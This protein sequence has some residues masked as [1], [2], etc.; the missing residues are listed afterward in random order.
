MRWSERTDIRAC[1]TAAVGGDLIMLYPR[2][3]CRCSGHPAI[4]ATTTIKHELGHAL[5][6]WHTDHVDDLMYGRENFGECDKNP[7]EREKYHAALAYSR[8][9]G[10]SAP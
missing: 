6:F 3:N 9:I 2:N 10:S 8:P 1:G 5:G 7:S 4:L